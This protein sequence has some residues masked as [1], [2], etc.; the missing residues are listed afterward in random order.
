MQEAASTGNRRGGSPRGLHPAQLLLESGAGFSTLEALIAIAVLTLSISAATLLVFGAQS[1]SID[2]AAN[3]DGLAVAQT[4]LENARATAAGS[5]GSVVSTSPSTANG[6]TS[7]LAV[8]DN[9]LCEKWVTG[10]VAWNVSSIRRQTISLTT[11]I[12]DPELALALGGDCDSPP[13]GGG[14][15]PGGGGG[16]T[17]TNPQTQGSANFNPGKPTSIDVLNAIVHLGSDK[18]PGI[19]IADATNPAAPFFVSFSNGFK[20]G[21]AVNGLD[22][23]R[24]AADNHVY[25]YIARDDKNTQFQIVDVT[26]IRNPVS[27]ATLGFPSVLPGGSFPQ[28]WRIVYFG[29]RAY[30]TVRET[31]GPEFHVVNVQDPSNPLEL[32]TGFEVNGT[33]TGFAVTAVKVNSI[34]HRVAY[35]ATKRDTKELMVLDVTDPTAVKEITAA[36]QNLSGTAD[37]RAIYL[38]GNRLYLGRD[39]GSGAELYIYDASYGVDGLGNLTV[40]LTLKGSKGIGTDIVALRT[41]RSKFGFIGT[42]KSNEEFQIWNIADPANITKISSY[43]FPNIIEGGVEVEGDY[44]YS[45][46]QANDSLRIIYSP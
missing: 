11:D 19:Q 20:V 36:N 21:V 31:A 9:G 10:N 3:A 2:T 32:G 18:D 23:A 35:L 34:S 25:A 39:A 12:S 16:P 6:Y 8:N 27:K 41:S 30:V 33:V 17:W 7:S 26:D 43:N 5:F 28:G 1:L 15:G 37:A 29:D 24:R 40:T 22:V 42:T 14:P 44:V 45:T 13:G 46:S 38:A 4:L